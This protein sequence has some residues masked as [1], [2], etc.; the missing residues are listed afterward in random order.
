MQLTKSYF[1]IPNSN[2]RTANVALH[3]FNPLGGIDQLVHG[4]AHLRGW[5]LPAFPDPTLYTV[6]GF[7]SPT[8]RFQYEVNPRFGNTRPA[9]SIVRAPFR[10]E[11]EV[12]LN[13]GPPLPLQQLERSMGA[14]RNRPGPKLTP[15]DLKKR[16]KRN[17]PDPY[18]AILEES[19]SLLISADQEK[20]LEAVQTEY[21]RGVDSLWTP[22]T[23][24]LAALGNSFD[25][26]EALR[27]QEETVDAV[28]EYS[29]LNVQK[30]LGTILSPVQINLL[31]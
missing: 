6:R 19:D 10:L 28:W 3:I 21:L 22:L 27:R 13:V 7:Y 29:R 14:G 17:V 31:P 24:Y 12:S 1:E 2:G 26:K 11:L 15:N 23:D 18:A 30:T 16:Y 5:G 8:H 20:A 4:S 9:N 25:S